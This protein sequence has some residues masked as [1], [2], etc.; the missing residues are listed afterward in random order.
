MRRILLSVQIIFRIADT[1]VGVDINTLGREMQRT[2][3]VLFLF[4]AGRARMQF[5][6]YAAVVT[7]LLGNSYR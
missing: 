2:S 6:A 3:I 5:A 7:G 4:I 1:G